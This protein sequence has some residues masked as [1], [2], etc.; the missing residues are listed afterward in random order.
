MGNCFCP[1]SFFLS[2]L[3]WC[4]FC[5]FTT[6]Y[7]LLLHQEDYSFHMFWERSV[8]ISIWV[9]GDQW[10]GHSRLHLCLLILMTDSRTSRAQLFVPQ[11]DWHP[12]LVSWIAVSYSGSRFTISLE[13]HTGGSWRNGLSA[14]SNI[15]SISLTQSLTIDPYLT[16]KLWHCVFRWRVS[17]TGFRRACQ[18]CFIFIDPV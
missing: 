10:Q 2:F 8:Y 15:P 16:R 4:F 14:V 18:V 7:L 5:T 1:I 17:K 9:I 6:I 12:Q 11:D 3:V 13:Y